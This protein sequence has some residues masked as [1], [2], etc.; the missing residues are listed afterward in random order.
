VLVVKMGAVVDDQDSASER[1]SGGGHIDADERDRIADEREAALNVR[2]ASIRDRE[3]AFAER[4]KQARAILEDAQ[5]RDGRADD[6]DS[7]AHD[8][9]RAASLASFLNDDDFAPGVE[10]RAAAGMD[11]SDSRDDRASAA[12]DRSR[13]TDEGRRQPGDGESDNSGV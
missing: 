9:D 8:R 11:R 10:A 2:E 12:V 6:R 5:L 1:P 4:K 13:L 3:V 7:I